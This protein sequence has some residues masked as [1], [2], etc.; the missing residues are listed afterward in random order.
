M[1]LSIRN[2]AFSPQL[3]QKISINPGSS[4][5]NH[6]LQNL[7][8]LPLHLFG[9]QTLQKMVLDDSASVFTDCLAFKCLHMK[10]TYNVHRRFSMSTFN[11]G[12][13]NALQSA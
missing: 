7:T 4:G 9:T 5:C 1:K 8:V 11:L 13:E 6:H 2:I 10:C 12:G 3:L